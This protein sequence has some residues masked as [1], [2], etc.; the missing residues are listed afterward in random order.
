MFCEVCHSLLAT[1]SDPSND[2]AMM[3]LLGKGG[4]A[5]FNERKNAN[6]NL[7]KGNELRTWRLG[8][9]REK[10]WSVAK[11]HIP[12]EERRKDDLTSSDSLDCSFVNLVMS[13][14]SHNQG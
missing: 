9:W 14:K 5:V 6:K 4:D 8:E 7:G 12:E 10:M 3:R 1:Q 11:K 2:T 13:S